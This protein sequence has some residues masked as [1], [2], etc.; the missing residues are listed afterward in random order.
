MEQNEPIKPSKIIIKPEQLSDSADGR[1]GYDPRIIAPSD[2]PDNLGYF[3]LL[4][5]FRFNYDD[6]NDTEK[7]NKLRKIYEWATRKSDTTEYADLVHTLR[8]LETR[9][10]Y[11]RYGTTFEQVYNYANLDLQIE[12]LLKERETMYDATLRSI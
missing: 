8:S 5:Y 4:D 11:P 6:R 3:K 2:L 10:G 7:S 9:L 1:V 12:S